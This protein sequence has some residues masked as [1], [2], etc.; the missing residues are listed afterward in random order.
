MLPKSILQ[1]MRNG[2]TVIT[3]NNR[4]S[5]QL[6]GQYLETSQYKTL[7]KPSCFAYPAFLREQ[8]KQYTQNNTT[9]THPRLLSA[10]H[11]QALWRKIL[12]TDAQLDASQNLLNT[13]HQAFVI[14]ENWQV[15]LPH[16]DFQATPQTELF[17]SVRFQFLNA[18]KA[19]DAITEHQLAAHVIT[20][21]IRPN[22]QHI[23]WVCFDDY[24]PVQKALQTQFNQL[25]ITQTHI[26]LDNIQSLSHQCIANDKQDEYTRILDFINTHLPKRIGII[27]PNLN[28]EAPQLQRYLKQYFKDDLFDFSLGK[29]LADYPLI[30]HALQ[31]LKLNLFEIN[32]HEIKLLLHSPYLTCAE[33]NHD[34]RAH[35]LHHIPLLQERTL[36]FETFKYALKH[37][38]PQLFHALDA[39]TPYPKQ[40]TPRQWAELFLK[41]L[42]QLGYPGEKPLNSIQYQCFERFVLLFDE[43]ATL[44]LIHPVMNA[45]SALEAF[46]DLT[47]FCIFQPEKQTAPINI[48]GLLEASGCEFDA[49]WLCNA[50]HQTLPSKAHLNAFIPITLQREQNMPYAH[51][52]REYELAEK[53]I[54]RLKQSAETLVFSYPARLNDIPTQASPLIIDL[55]LYS[56]TPI[57]PQ[58]KLALIQS[59]EI[60]QLPFTS[61]DSIKGGSSRL[62]NQALC[63]FRAFAAH[64]LHAT[65]PPDITDGPDASIRGQVI[66]HVLEQL[67]RLLGSQKALLNQST[68][69]LDEKINQAIH[70]ALIPLQ[71]NKPHSFPKLVQSI[72]QERLKR[73]VHAALHWDKTRDAFKIEALEASFTLTL[74]ALLFRVRLDRL[75]SLSSGEKWLIDYKSRIPSPLPFDEERPESPQLLLYALLDN[76]IRGLLFLELKK[77]HVAC[78]GFAED[79]KNI[80]GIKS[81]KPDENWSSYQHLWHERLTLL[82]DEFHQGFCPPKPKK[83]S[84]CQT[85]S[86]HSLCRI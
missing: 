79:A 73:L 27:V 43:L 42:K 56:H 41:R 21:Q 37:A 8:F 7:P 45:K 25:N 76:Q 74:G 38:T 68:E 34:T 17:E 29:P 69:M 77:G 40:A 60:Y 22:T 4:L 57:K 48:L 66:H 58:S 49:I 10:A 55:P 63:P 71:K 52:K 39:L 13:I 28:Q 16:K 5:E 80:T 9:S 32:H 20:H 54:H 31:W 33:E 81:L 72:E 35:A 70:T 30:A 3:P 51:A 83:T 75:D 14:C 24:T 85:C 15:A 46:Q 6:L 82:A 36:S 62:V 64:R 2:A 1:A 11:I 44:S 78:R 26:E 19:L 50:T 86:F 61:L 23:L 53:R 59:N 67:W 47:K 65:A 12:S 18:L 84:T